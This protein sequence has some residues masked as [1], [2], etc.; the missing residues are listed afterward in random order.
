MWRIAVEARQA[1]PI[2]A[3][4]EYRGLISGGTTS[5]SESAAKNAPI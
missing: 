2:A 5:A 4:Q 1:R 3:S